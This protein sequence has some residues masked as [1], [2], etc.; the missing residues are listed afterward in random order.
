MNDTTGWRIVTLSAVILLGGLTL[1]SVWYQHL[2]RERWLR[3]ELQSIKNELSMQISTQLQFREL[4]EHKG[5]NI[6]PRSMPTP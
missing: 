1:A 5:M 6:P 4:R 3:S 2:D